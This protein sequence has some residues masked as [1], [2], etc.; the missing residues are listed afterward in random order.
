MEAFRS[1]LEPFWV[2]NA[3]AVLGGFEFWVTDAWAIAEM[4]FP[5]VA[6]ADLN[7]SRTD[8]VAVADTPTLFVSEAPISVTLPTLQGVLVR[9]PT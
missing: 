8:S 9:G 4:T 3:S 2:Q 7:V 5:S 1:E 6:G